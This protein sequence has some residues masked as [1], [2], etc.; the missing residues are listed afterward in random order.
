[1]RP[2][3]PEGCSHSSSKPVATTKAVVARPEFAEGLGPG[4]RLLALCAESSHRVRQLLGLR[5][6]H[7]CRTQ[8]G[9]QPDDVRVLRGLGEP[10]D[11]RAQRKAPTVHDSLEGMGTYVLDDCPGEV[12]LE[13]DRHVLD[14]T[15]ASRASRA[16]GRPQLAVT[17]S[18]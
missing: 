5:Q 7:R 17:A 1:M 15:R 4:D 18:R 3:L 11:E 16:G 14:R 8:L 13:Q 2:T 9:Q 6:R 12:H 10:V